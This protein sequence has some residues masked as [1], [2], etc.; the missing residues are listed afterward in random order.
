[1]ITNSNLTHGAGAVL[2]WA[3][4]NWILVVSSVVDMVMFV[5]KKSAYPLPPLTSQSCAVDSKIP[6]NNPF[7]FPD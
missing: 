4:V 6:R 3:L 1:M 5:S 2:I 7:Y